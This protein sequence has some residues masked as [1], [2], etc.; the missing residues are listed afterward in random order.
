MGS[1]CP[2]GGGG[3]FLIAK[4]SIM[5]GGAN[6]RGGGQGVA[7][8]TTG[9]D[10]VV[11]A[12]TNVVVVATSTHATWSF[13]AASQRLPGRPPRPILRL[14]SLRK[15]TEV[16]VISEYLPFRFRSLDFSGGV[17]GI[18]SEEAIVSTI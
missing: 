10:S 17:T 1:D 8:L 3:A 15:D 13:G 14:R 6:V 2:H 11:V 5:S 16:G 7:G 9:D 4:E 12:P 18:E